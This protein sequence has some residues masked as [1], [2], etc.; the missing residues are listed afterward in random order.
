MGYAASRVIGWCVRDTFITREEIKGLMNG[1]LCVNA[2]P[3]GKTRLT[4]WMRANAH[5]LGRN[6]A[7][8][9][10]RRQDRKSPY[11]PA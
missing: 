7:S 2:P 8:E 9:L 4:G 6:Y 5:R 11:F 3:T 10:G 1:L